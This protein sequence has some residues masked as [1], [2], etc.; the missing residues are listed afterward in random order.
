MVV[1][2]SLSSRSVGRALALLLAKELSLKV[3]PK[4]VY[5]DYPFQSIKAI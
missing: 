1:S 4:S 2:G 3:K 5:A